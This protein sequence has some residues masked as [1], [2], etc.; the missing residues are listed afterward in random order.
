MSSDRTKSPSPRACGERGWGEGFRRLRMARY[1]A[2]S[3]KLTEPKSFGSPMQLNGKAK[4]RAR[5]LA[6]PTVCNKKDAQRGCA[7]QL[8]GIGKR[9]LRLS[10]LGLSPGAPHPQP[11]SPQARGEGRG[12]SGPC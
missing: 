2:L 9:E 12:I 5:S 1:C 10:Q 11:L 6:A 8:R 3:P 7:L 4:V